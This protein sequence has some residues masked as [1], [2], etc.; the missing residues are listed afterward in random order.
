M[1]LEQTHIHVHVTGHLAENVNFYMEY[2]RSPE[3]RARGLEEAKARGF[4]S[5]VK[6]VRS[7]LLWNPHRFKGTVSPV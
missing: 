1:G 4:V 6:D 2:L 7:K 5:V 3:A